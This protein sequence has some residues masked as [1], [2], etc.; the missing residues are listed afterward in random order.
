MATVFTTQGST[1]GTYDGRYLYLTINETTNAKTNKS[2][3]AWTLTVTG[4]STANYSTGA[5]TVKINGTT[6]K[7]KVFVTQ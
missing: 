2:T 1:Y 7:I 5:T 6:V 4:G 3:L